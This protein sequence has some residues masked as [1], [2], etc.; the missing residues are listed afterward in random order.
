MYSYEPTI[1][2]I[3]CVKFFNIS[4]Y[5]PTTISAVSAQIVLKR[6]DNFMIKRKSGKS[7][8][9]CL[10]ISFCKWFDNKQCLQ[11]MKINNKP[12]RKHSQLSSILLTSWSRKLK[13]I[14]LL[15]YMVM[16]K[17]SSFQCPNCQR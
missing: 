14:V 2:H 5:D 6:T 11:D 15:T 7:N 3:T 10:Y 12:L 9:S 4:I 13:T 17:I 16:K 1:T 8:I